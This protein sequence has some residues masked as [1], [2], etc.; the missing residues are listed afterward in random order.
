[1]KRVSKVLM[2]AAASLAMTGIALA[3]E[4]AATEP[5]PADATPAPAEPAAAPAPAMAAPSATALTLGKG[6]IVI[7][8]STLNVNLSASAVGKPVSLAPSVNYGVSDKLTIGLSHDGGTTQFTPRPAV[9]AG[10]CVTG[11]DNGCGKVYNNLGI[12]ALF[13]LAAGKFSVAAHP[14]LDIR[15]L[16]PLT[17]S[18]R[19]GVLGRY[20]V[21]PKVAIVFDPRLSIGLNKRDG[22]TDPTTGIT[23]GGNKEQLDIPV[24]AWFVA[25]DKLGAYVS[26]GI[27]GPLD[28]FGDAFTV[29]VGVGA[30]FKASEKLSVGGDFFFFNLLG[31]NSSADFRF[32]GIRAAFAL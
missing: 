19:V 25:S 4:P 10:I 12:D 17:M 15:S 5:A 1:M 26:T 30:T 20:E 21:A 29:P 13:S 8:G 16:D 27:N 3:E 24:Y 2:I 14:G 23:I 6:K 22:A 9:G 31:K 28:G 32:L 18:L 7:A 11:K